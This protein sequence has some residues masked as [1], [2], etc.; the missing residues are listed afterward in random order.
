MFLWSFL[1]QEAT[2]VVDGASELIDIVGDIYSTLHMYQFSNNCGYH[3]L[4]A[5]FI[6]CLFPAVLSSGIAMFFRIRAFHQKLQDRERDQEQHSKNTRELFSRTFQTRRPSFCQIV[7][8]YKLA[9]DR[10][11]LLERQS[12]GVSTRMSTH[13]PAHK[14]A[15]VSLRTPTHMSTHMPAHMPAHVELANIG[16]SRR[17]PGT[18][19]HVLAP[20]CCIGRGPTVLRSEHDVRAGTEA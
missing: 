18:A 16:V 9:Q 13:V 17:C 4:W 12:I 7:Q 11:D 19:A 3:E 5:A 20:P 8:F 14:P 2:L 6:V 15:H 1:N 10:R